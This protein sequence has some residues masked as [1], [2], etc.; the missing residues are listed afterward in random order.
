VPGYAP[1]TGATLRF[2]TSTGAEQEALSTVPG[3]TERSGRWLRGQRGEFHIKPVE[4][5]LGRRSGPSRGENGKIAFDS[6][7]LR[8]TKGPAFDFESDWQ[9]LLDGDCHDRRG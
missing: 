3:T 7:Q 4:R 2:S 6:D 8:L 9:P 1:G 5:R